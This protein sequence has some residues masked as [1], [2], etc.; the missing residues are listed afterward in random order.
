MSRQKKINFSVMSDSDI[1]ALMD[2]VE[3]EDDFEDSDNS[4]SDPDYICDQINPD[5]DGM[6][7]DCLQKLD[8]SS[9]MDAIN[10]TMN[11][12]NISVNSTQ[13]PTTSNE[14]LAQTRLDETGAE[15]HSTQKKTDSEVEKS[16]KSQKRARSP[17]PAIEA[18]GPKVAP[19]D[20]G[21]TGGDLD[22]I[23]KDS[24]EFKN[25]VW[26]KRFMQL[27]VNEVAF[28]GKTDLPSEVKKLKTPID[29]FTYFFTDELFE[30]IY[31][32]TNR[33]LFCVVTSMLPSILVGKQLSGYFR[34]QNTKKVQKLPHEASCR[35][36][37]SCYHIRIRLVLFCGKEIK[38]QE[39]SVLL[40]ETRELYLKNYG[41]YNMP[42]SVHTVLVHGCDVI[43]Y[44][45]LPIGSLSE[46]ALE[47]SHKNHTR[48]TGRVQS[49]TDLMTRLILSSDPLVAFKRN[50]KQRNK[51][52]KGS[53]LSFIKYIV[54]SDEADNEM[55]SSEDSE[56]D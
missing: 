38:T 19:S 47:C 31:M 2:S 27:H 24:L 32:E 37:E 36:E 5:E 51:Y 29:F 56:T 11:T 18:S 26:R 55:E 34:E 40:T 44:F 30:L 39:F 4:I 16:Y 25:I 53:D 9:F 10:L 41:W 13:T 8:D 49:N 35:C 17:L 3:I 7:N 42:S 33:A 48:K 20:G 12:S 46:E 22:N 43:K 6:I 23:N 15:S 21:F 45:D 14:V 50:I 1:E 54:E 52:S 28:R